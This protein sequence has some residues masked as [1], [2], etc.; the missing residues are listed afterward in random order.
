MGAGVA[1]VAGVGAIKGARVVERCV[2]RGWD[3]D[4]NRKRNEWDGPVEPGE[5]CGGTAEAVGGCVVGV[6]GRGGCKAGGCAR[7]SVGLEKRY[8]WA[9]SYHSGEGVGCMLIMPNFCRIDCSFATGDW[10]LRGVSVLRLDQ[11]A[12]REAVQAACFYDSYEF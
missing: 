4:D 7:D 9:L 10:S 3:N 11:M 5:A 8:E 6:G 1:A 2:R 12:A